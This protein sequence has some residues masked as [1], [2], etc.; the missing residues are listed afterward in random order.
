MSHH[1]S[2]SHSSLHVCLLPLQPPR[3]EQTENKIKHLPMEAAVCHAVHPFAQAALLANV[4]CNGHWSG[5]RP[6]A[7]VT[8]SILDFHQ[9]HLGYPVVVLCPGGSAALV[10]KDQPLHAL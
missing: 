9:T 5:L 6:L 10:L 1:A 7:S 2:Q 8:L 3:K 4:H